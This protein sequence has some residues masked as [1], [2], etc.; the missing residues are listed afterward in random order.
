[1]A[2]WLSPQRGGF[3]HPTQ[4]SGSVWALTRNSSRAHVCAHTPHSPSH[5]ILTPPQSHTRTLIPQTHKTVTYHPH[6][7]TYTPSHI[8]SHTRVCT[9]IHTLTCAPF[10]IRSENTVLHTTHTTHTTQRAETWRATVEFGSRVF[11][12]TH[13]LEAWSPVVLL[14][15]SGNFKVLGACP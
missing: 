7:L 4:W 15:G 11:P 8:H 1:V 10:H 2:R 3:N 13:I 12:Q 5:I 6:T 14:G 9:H